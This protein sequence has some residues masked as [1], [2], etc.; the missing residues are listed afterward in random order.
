MFAQIKD[1]IP[2]CG[3]ID[4]QSKLGNLIQYDLVSYEGIKCYMFTRRCP[5]CGKENIY[6]VKGLN[7]QSR[8]QLLPNIDEN[9]IKI[10]K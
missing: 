9:K 5:K 10:I 6:V 3:D 4:C 1:N 2:Y 7:L 8:G